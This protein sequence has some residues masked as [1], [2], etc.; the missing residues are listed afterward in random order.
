MTAKRIRLA[1]SRPK[2]LLAAQTYANDPLKTSFHL[3]VV[4]VQLVTL[5]VKFDI[6]SQCSQNR[7]ISS[8]QIQWPAREIELRQ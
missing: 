4:T 3:A 8:E 2:V 6:S 5:P 7:R 1:Y